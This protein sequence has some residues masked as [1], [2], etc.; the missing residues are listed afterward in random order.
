MN[1]LTP[2]S[3]GRYTRTFQLRLVCNA[4]L[5]SAVVVFGKLYSSLSLAAHMYRQ[6][7]RYGWEALP[8]I[9]RF[10]VVAGWLP[11]SLPLVLLL[12]GS[13]LQTRKG[14][15]GVKKAVALE[16]I[17]VLQQLFAL[18]WGGWI[19]LAWK[20]AETPYRDSISGPLP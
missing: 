11:L 7:D 15:S 14:T 18:G 13:F 19:I 9:T 6:H 4:G 8:P 3:D 16:A 1:E 17:L 20:L 5:A 10:T 12:L 2:M